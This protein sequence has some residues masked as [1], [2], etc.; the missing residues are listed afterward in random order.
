MKHQ[1]SKPDQINYLQYLF[2]VQ[3]KVINR[4]ALAYM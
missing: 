1:V 4:Y 2:D 3:N